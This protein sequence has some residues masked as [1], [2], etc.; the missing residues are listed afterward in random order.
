MQQK[1]NILQAIG[2]TPLV[3][4]LKL[5]KNLAPEIFAKLEYF[6][7]SGSV[8][9]R[10]ALEIIE[11][12]ER[13]GRLRPGGT[14]IEATTGNTGISIAL[15]AAVKGYKCI[16]V[17]PD[18]ISIE[19]V[20]LLRAYGADVII[21]PDAVP[22]DSPESYTE[23]AKRIVRETPNSILANQFFN[24]K[25]FETHYKTTGPEIWEQTQG[26]I[27][28]FI[29]GIGTGGTIS[30]IGKFLKE[31]NPEIKIIGVDPKGSILREFF[32]T[33]KVTQNFFPYKLESIG[34]D[35]IPGTLHIEY[36][37]EIMEVTDKDAFLTARKLTTE[38]GIFAGG[39]SGAVVSAALK[40]AQNLS[41]ENLIVALLPDSG[42]RYLSKI[43]NENWM[44]EN[45][46]FIPEKVTIRYV[47]QSKSKK[48]PELISID[49][50]DTVQHALDL[51]KAHDISQ[52]PVFEQNKPVG[53]IEDS[54]LMAAVLENS[55][56]IAKNVSSVMKPTFPIIGIDSPIER[57]IELLTKKTSAILV[58]EKKKIIG[59]ITRYD[60]IE[61]ITK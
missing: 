34:A 58:E 25:N 39:S 31:Q 51:F 55:T 49:I 22:H 59:I 1:E 23:V 29:A 36:I 45:G 28:H 53:S 21:T 9:D 33:K 11:D 14:I 15:V 6:N 54:E 43:Y 8:K 24:P 61:F 7:P 26:K 13:D 42:E 46:F 41:V 38:E 32:I 40:L 56:L 35:W 48:L 16:F 37:D 60:I 52:I 50:N 17:V 10:I 12:A 18:K 2:N 47:L 30:G 44:R 5:T 3:K 19:K 57:A 27:T 4:L 20:Q